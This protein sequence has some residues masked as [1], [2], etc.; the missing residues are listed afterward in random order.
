MA[1]HDGHVRTHAHCACISVMRPA[2]TA[3]AIR[4]FPRRPESPPCRPSHLTADVGGVQRAQDRVGG[5]VGATAQGPSADCPRNCRRPAFAPSA[6]PRR[7]SVSCRRISG[8]PSPGPGTPQR[9]C[10]VEAERVG[11]RSACSCWATWWMTGCWRWAGSAGLHLTIIELP[12]NEQR[13]WYSGAGQDHH[14]PRTDVA[15]GT[16]PQLRPAGCG[17]AGLRPGPRSALRRVGGRYFRGA[18]ATVISTWFAGAREACQPLWASRV[19]LRL[20]V[21]TS[22]IE[23]ALALQTAQCATAQA[24]GP[25]RLDPQHAP[26]GRGRNVAESR[27][28]AFLARLPDPRP[29]QGRAACSQVRR[30]SGRSRRR[31]R[32]APWAHAGHKLRER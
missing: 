21:P 10:P 17:P 5:L 2:W 16:F 7:S 18:G 28:Q 23:R 1:D 12:L 29:H 14:E 26:L 4:R 11:Q 20:S 3:R 27:G 30:G 19:Q 9:I 15:A 31:R 32:P 6:I 22:V 13:A 24:S 8:Q 25:S